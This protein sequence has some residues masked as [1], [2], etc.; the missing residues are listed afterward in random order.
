MA[1]TDDSLES[2][3]RQ[4]QPNAKGAANA[5]RWLDLLGSQRAAG[6]FPEPAA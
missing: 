5:G 6:G 4:S 2:P 1:N 3:A